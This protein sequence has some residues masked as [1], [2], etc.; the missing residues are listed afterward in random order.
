M[1]EDGDLVN[2][3]ARDLCLIVPH[4]DAAV[5]AALRGRLQGCLSTG[6]GQ[7]GVRAVLRGQGR[8]CVDV[9]HEAL[10]AWTPSRA[11]VRTARA[12]AAG[13]GL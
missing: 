8:L 2:L 4:E 7:A 9:P 1:G 10:F 11:G 6:P 3:L 5:G 12:A 13:G